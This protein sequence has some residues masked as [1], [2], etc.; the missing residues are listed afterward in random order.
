MSVRT[1]NPARAAPYGDPV[2]RRQWTVTLV[3]CTGDGQLLGALPPFTV[4]TPH[5]P[6]ADEL[7]EGARRRHGVE[8]TVLRLLRTGA[9]EPGGPVAYL[10]QLNGR[11]PERLAHWPG[12]PLAPHPLRLSYA[13]PGGP[14][15]DLAWA[16]GRLRALELELAGA[17]T[18]MRTW[19]LSSIWR[20]PTSAGAVWLKVVPPFLDHEGALLR[21]LDTGIVP[22]VLAAEGPRLLMGHVPGVDQYDADE[23]QLAR[24]VA[25][26][27]DLQ[28]RQATRMS[29][30]FAAGLPDW[31]AEPLRTLASTTFE[32]HADELAPAERAALT[33]LLDGWS[34]RHAAIAEC[35][36][37]D[38]LVHGDLHPGNVRGEGPRLVI[39]DWG[40]SGV[41]HP[42]LDQSSFLERAPEPAARRL[43]ATW[44]RAWRDAVPGSD[45]DRA[46]RLVEPVAALRR[47]V[48]YQGFLERIEPDERVYHARDPLDWLRRGAALASAK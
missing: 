12:D 9:Q 22:P 48:V 21:V 7:V 43:R 16:R 45:P 34:E 8:V 44:A 19:N 20:I 36:L 2:E 33:G 4:A 1:R 42:L 39:L 6:Q 14:D 26:I 41:G 18:Q 31:R 5:W 3:L 15:A 40:D 24:M 13:N 37:P 47:A 38:T 32:A 46:A 23:R 30:L 28:A 35:G 25:L 27:V 29:D 11:A 10:A 17:P